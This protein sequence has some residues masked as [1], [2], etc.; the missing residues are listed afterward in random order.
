M[1]R[2]YDYIAVFLVAD[3]IMAS[4]FIPYIGWVIAWVL[5]EVIWDAYC[6]FRKAQEKNQ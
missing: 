5:F 1:I 2:W 6:L 4:L 3:L